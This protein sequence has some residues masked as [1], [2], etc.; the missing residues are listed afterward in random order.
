MGTALAVPYNFLIIVIPRPPRR[1]GE[2]LF[3]LPFY[4][5]FAAPIMGFLDAIIMTS[6]K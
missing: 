5:A 6:V 1:A 3:F 4:W 2:L